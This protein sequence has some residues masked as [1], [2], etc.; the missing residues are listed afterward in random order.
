MPGVQG[1]TYCVPIW[2][3]FYEMVFGSQTIADFRTP[4]VLPT[5][6]PWT[7]HYSLLAPA[8]APSAAPSARPTAPSPTNQPT[9]TTPQPTAPSPTN[10]PTT[11]PAP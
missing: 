4:A 6:R 3:S 9:P 5:Y 1:A 2:G 7:G 8:P 10:Q 11:A